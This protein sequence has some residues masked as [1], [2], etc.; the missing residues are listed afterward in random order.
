MS[1]SEIIARR[2]A[3][4]VAALNRQDIPVL[5]AL[6]AEDCTDIPPNRPAIRGLSAIQD[7]WREGFAQV[8]TRFAIFPEQLEIGGDIAVERFRWTVESAPL[9]GGSSTRDE[10]VGVWTWRREKD[11]AWKIAQAIWNSD[12]PQGQTV[13]TG[14][15]R[16]AA[17]L[18]TEDQD[19]IRDLV[20]QQWPAAWLARDLGKVLAM[21][22]EDVVYMPADHAALRG[23]A[24]LRAWLEKFPKTLK[25]TQPLTHLEGDAHGAVARATFDAAIEVAGE[26][27]AIVG[28]VLCTLRKEPN[29]KWLA[30]SVCWNF[31][32]PVPAAPESDLGARIRSAN[33][34]LLA[35][36]NVAA[37]REIFSSAYVVHFNGGDLRGTQAIEQYV[38]ELRSAFPDLRYE[39]QILASTEDK[40][41]WVRTHHGTHKGAFMG[42]LASGRAITWRDM[43]LTRYEGGRIA[44]EW[45]VTDIGE[46]L[47]AP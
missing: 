42:A 35:K 46:Q 14:A 24:D 23:Q 33:D 12:L 30:Q 29:G 22:T 3:E 39:I 31:D 45:A 27:I 44:E 18:T 41:S 40:V 34:E 19:T 37:A 6:R 11:A 25:F 21:C 16:S 43:V 17:P 28:K 7:F 36:G 13:W 5:S 38:T 10:G 26:P 1:D 47:R 15:S 20:E 32:R 2:G 8:E 9:S 4:F